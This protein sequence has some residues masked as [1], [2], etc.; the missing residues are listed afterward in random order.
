MILRG[1]EQTLELRLS[2]KHP[3]T[4]WLV[5]R[6]A[7]LLLKFHVGDD[8]KT[9]YERWKWKPFHGQEIEFGENVHHREDIKA[10][11]KKNKLEIR[12]GEGHYLGRWW[13][14]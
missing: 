10:R 12:R 2:G 3:V 14:F 7:D 8:G 6:V 5:E 9:G 13:W 1:L 4:A 11:A